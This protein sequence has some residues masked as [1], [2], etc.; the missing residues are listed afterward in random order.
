[1]LIGAGGVRRA[2]YIQHNNHS[3][4]ALQWVCVRIG[5]RVLRAPY[6]MGNEGQSVTIVRS[7]QDYHVANSGAGR[8]LR[9][10]HRAH[11][12]DKYGVP[13]ICVV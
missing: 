9:K 5:H 7:W 4:G 1:M 8:P 2:E 13:R 11:R 3:S 6:L 10:Y 12:K